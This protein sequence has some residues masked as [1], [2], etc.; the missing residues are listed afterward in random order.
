MGSE[1]FRGLDQFDWY[2]YYCHSCG[3]SGWLG[4]DRGQ[5]VEEF[6]E[7]AIMI[8]G[9]PPVCADCRADQRGLMNRTGRR[10]LR[11]RAGRRP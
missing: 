1:D 7:M 2:G 5:S 9:G 8:L 10:A 6:A 3:E 11:R 4:R